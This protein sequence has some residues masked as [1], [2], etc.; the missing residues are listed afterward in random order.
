MHRR[1]RAWLAACVVVAVIEAGI[2]L[3]RWQLPIVGIAIRDEHGGPPRPGPAVPIPTHFYPPWVLRGTVIERLARAETRMHTGPKERS[4]LPLVLLF[5]ASGVS[6]LVYQVVWMRELTL[7]LGISTLATA[8]VL[9]AF[10][11]G[12]GLGGRPEDGRA[13]V[14]GRGDEV[15]VA[16]LLGFFDV[17]EDGVRVA[18]GAGEHTD[19]GA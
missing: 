15:A 19:A 2:V 7:V 10:M 17:I 9:T 11:G 5:V 4:L 8:A 1:G 13:E 6:G 12:F 14:A 3:A 16:T 18:D